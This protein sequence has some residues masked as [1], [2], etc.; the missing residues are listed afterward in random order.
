[1]TR[2]VR[3]ANRESQPG[4]E[5]LEPLTTEVRVEMIRAFL[6]ELTTPVIALTVLLRID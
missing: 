1:M 6:F 2:Y 5:K 3:L 4:R